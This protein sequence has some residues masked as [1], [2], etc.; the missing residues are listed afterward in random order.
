M[1]TPTQDQALPPDLTQDE[2]DAICD[3]LKQPAAQIRFLTRLGVR[4]E[5]R[6]NGRPLVSRLHYVEVRHGQTA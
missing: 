4:V 3:P 1:K 6:P 5:R 2:I